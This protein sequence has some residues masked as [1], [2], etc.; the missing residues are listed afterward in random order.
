[1]KLTCH[2]RKIKQ[3]K[4]W[5]SLVILGIGFLLG[6]VLDALVEVY[7]VALMY[8][9][10]DYP[11]EAFAAVCSVA[12]LGNAVLSLLFGSLE[13]TIRGIPFQ[14]VLQYS[15][16]GSDQ[17]LTI[18]ATMMSI[19]L[20]IFAYA[21][22][23]CTTL[24]F[25]V[26]LDAFLILSSS[27]DLWRIL[28][29]SSIHKKIVN[30]VL[31]DTEH[32]RIIV[33]IDSWFENLSKSLESENERSVSDFCDLISGIPAITD[34]D[35][36]PINSA[37]ASHFPA[38][39]ESA[40]EKIG[41]VSAY[42]IIKL[43]NA[44]RPDGFVDCEST[45]VDYIN[46][47]KY[48]N[49]VNGHNRSIPIVVD[50]IIKKLE[51]EDWEKVSFGYR[52]FSAVFDNP[53][54]NPDAKRALLVELLDV[55]TY[56]RE[57]NEGVVKK[58]ILMLI[59]KHD[60]ILNNGE[61]SREF[62][63][64]LMTESLLRNNRYVH[65]QPFIG[66]IAE[67]FRA[68]FFYIYRENETLTQKYR[69][70]LLTL[71][72]TKQGEKDIISLTFSHLIAENYEK[73]I[74]WLAED[75]TIFDRKKKLFWDYFS[76]TTGFKNIVWNTTELIRFAFCFRKIIGYRCNTFPFVDIVES[77]NYDDYEKIIVCRE[78][79]NLYDDG[80]LN[81]TAMHNIHQIEALIGI[82][83]SHSNHDS[84]EHDFFQDKLSEIANKMT[85]EALNQRPLTDEKM[86][87]MV[88]NHLQ[89]RC[90]FEWD[91]DLE[92]IPATK[93]RIEPTLV[94]LNVHQAENSAYRIAQIIKMVIN[95]VIE[96]KLQKIYVNFGAEGIETLLENLG[97][98]EWNYRNY[99]HINDYAIPS[100]VRKTDTFKRL[101]ET[102]DGIHYDNSHEIT[103]N[104]FLKAQNVPYN[105]SLHYSLEDPTE[106]NCAEFVKKHQIAEGVYQIGGNRWD[107][108][109][110]VKYVR[111]HYKLELVDFSVRVDVS[112]ESG[113][114]VC[115]S[116]N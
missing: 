16:F 96:R 60:I 51:V 83:A 35:K 23:L 26:C 39:F 80:E 9:K 86:L 24:T 68:F 29:D 33:Y 81:E 15:K 7:G 90:V 63:L 11:N 111:K 113:F 42:R 54:L 19:V 100:E 14:D 34:E 1:M 12:V 20:A 40:C 114:R 97:D 91:A 70:G 77:D 98:D 88:N 75:A 65:D 95:G 72:H 41:F 21:Q 106:G 78:I 109:H 85:Q 13:R 49:A 71:F 58:E 32:A 6:L 45:A 64:N 53:Y 30:D 36:H 102:F 67:I 43:I 8:V 79:I 10:A 4:S 5:K 47:L 28:S 66:T 76:P 115:F 61:T 56:L 18:V 31:S 116:R 57:G 27:I 37:I 112:R 73:V 92:L 62:L 69:D 55:L 94:E 110:A 82:H 101:C 46:T 93:R 99:I 38:F 25:L 107:Y 59:T 104:V 74:V 87:Q 52:Y 44:V 84:V 3:I 105:I 103:S 108:S 50:E 2:I 48:Y 89:K 17:Q 22:E